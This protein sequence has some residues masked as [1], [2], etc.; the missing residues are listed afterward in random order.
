MI[1][2][3]HRLQVQRLLRG[4]VQKTAGFNVGRAR[5][6]YEQYKAAFSTVQSWSISD[7]SYKI[8]VVAAEAVL[9]KAEKTNL[10]LDDSTMAEV[11]MV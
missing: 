5:D 10:Y 9:G 11:R 8:N 3:I 4:E 7:I 6:I 1:P 2:G